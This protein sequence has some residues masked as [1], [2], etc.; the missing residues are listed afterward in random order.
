[1][2]I[3][4]LTPLTVDDS[5]AVKLSPGQRRVPPTFG[6]KFP[7]TLFIVTDGGLYLGDE[8]VSDSNASLM[9]AGTY[10]ITLENDEELYGIAPDGESVIVKRMGQGLEP[11]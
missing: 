4:N 2:A 5:E 9:P 11:A 8:D 3:V 7:I 10:S 6:Q 1:M